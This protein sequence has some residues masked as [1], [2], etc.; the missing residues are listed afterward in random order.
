LKENTDKLR[1]IERFDGRSQPI[2]FHCIFFGVCVG[3]VENLEGSLLLNPII[4]NVEK[5]RKG[6]GLRE[7]FNKMCQ[8]G[9]HGGFSGIHVGFVSQ[10]EAVSAV[11]GI[12][13]K[14]FHF[15]AGHFFLDLRMHL[16]E[17]A[18]RQFIFLAKSEKFARFLDCANS[19]A[20]YCVSSKGVVPSF[21]FSNRIKFHGEEI[22]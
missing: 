12:G 11:F 8:I 13:R 18:I 7:L 1:L 3:L 6:L 5:V 20:I 16:F 22:G 2:S 17:S 15:F 4:S 21:D 19:N 14:I 9:L 10:T